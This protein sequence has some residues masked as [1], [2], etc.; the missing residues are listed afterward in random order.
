MSNAG[1]SDDKNMSCRCNFLGKKHFYDFFNQMM[2]ISVL[3]KFA[4]NRA[5]KLKDNVSFY[6]EVCI[7]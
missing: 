4:H 5:T 2:L 7:S 3:L 1:T 6:D